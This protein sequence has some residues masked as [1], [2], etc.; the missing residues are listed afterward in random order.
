MEAVKGKKIIFLFRKYSAGA[1]TTGRVIAFTTDN[2]RSASL[3]ADVTA[4]KDGPIRTPGDPDITVS[5]TAL[6]VKGDS[7]FDTYEDAML[8]AELIECWKVNLEEPVDGQSGKYKGI[9][10]QGYFTSVEESSSADGFVEMS[11]NYSANGKGARG[12][13]TVTAEEQEIANYVFQDSTLRFT[14]TPTSLSIA[15]S[16]LKIFSLPSGFSAAFSSWS[17]VRF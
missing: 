15:T 6:L 14:V 12:N 10:Y 3:D 16:P 13:V 5:A 8:N 4:T 2:S 9:Y 11:L 17:S 7:T 1:S